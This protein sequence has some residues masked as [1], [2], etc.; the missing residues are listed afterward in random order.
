MLPSTCRAAANLSFRVPHA[1]S[2]VRV[3]F[4]SPLDQAGYLPCCL[5]TQSSACD[6]AGCVPAEQ[7]CVDAGDAADGPQLPEVGRVGAGPPGRHAHHRLHVQREP[8]TG[9]AGGPPAAA[10][11][12]AGRCPQ[13]RPPSASAAH[14]L[15]AICSNLSRRSI[16]NPDVRYVFTVSFDLN[17]FRFNLKSICFMPGAHW[18]NHKRKRSRP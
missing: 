7:V 17:S 12:P 18:G 2:Y 5:F 10:Q 3:A 16:R 9:A 14:I 4:V 8:T 11:R 15:L 13:V 6:S 1:Y